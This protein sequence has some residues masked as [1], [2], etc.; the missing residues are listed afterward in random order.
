MADGRA[1]LSVCDKVN[2]KISLTPEISQCLVYNPFPLTFISKLGVVGPVTPGFR[3]WV[4]AREL[5]VRFKDYLVR[6]Y[7]R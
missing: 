7:G 2:Y 3:K 5:K 4:Q 6:C 1:D